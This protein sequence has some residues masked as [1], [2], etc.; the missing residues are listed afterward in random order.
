M[1]IETVTLA[2]GAVMPE[3]VTVELVEPPSGTVLMPRLL[4]EKPRPCE[5]VGSTSGTEKVPWLEV[6]N[7]SSSSMFCPQTNCGERLIWKGVLLVPRPVT[8]MFGYVED[9]CTM[10]TLG[11][12]ESSVAEIF[13][14]V[15]VPLR[16]LVR[17]MLS[18]LHSLG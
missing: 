10:L 11:V 7:A 17:T 9:P 6:V 4:K 1:F 12:W 3:T 2:M 5:P 14:I 13:E 8:P 16:R 18:R 15:V